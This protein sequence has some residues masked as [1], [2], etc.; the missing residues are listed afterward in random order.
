AF[1]VVDTGN[2]WNLG[3]ADNDVKTLTAA[4]HAKNVKVLVSIGGADDDIGI[5]NQYQTQSNID[6]LAANLDA[7]ITR[8]N[9]DWVAGGLERGANMKSSSNYP[10]FVN[11]LVA[12]LRPEGKLVTTALAQ[13]IVEDAGVDAGLKAV[14]NSFDFINLMIYSTNP[15]NYTSELGWWTTN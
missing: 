6:P 4:A 5:M 1:G 14:L 12:T 9:L 8:L 11:K 3:A 13:Y 10:A 7:F 15:S 2:N